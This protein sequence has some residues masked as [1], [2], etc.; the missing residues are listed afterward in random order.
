VREASVDETIRS[1]VPYM[2]TETRG[3]GDVLLQKG[4]P[5]DRVYV[6][7]NGRVRVTEI[8]KVM[9]EGGVFGGGTVRAAERPHPSTGQGACGRFAN[10]AVAAERAAADGLPDAATVPVA[11]IPLT[12]QGAALERVDI[13]TGTSCAGCSAWARSPT[14]SVKGKPNARALDAALGLRITRLA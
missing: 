5:E 4:G 11:T 7:Q 3:A 13:C 1:P 14:A 9:S 2:P 8:R 6:I 12:I 10:A